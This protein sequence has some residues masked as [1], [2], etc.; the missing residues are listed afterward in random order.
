M[1]CRLI[2]AIVVSRGNVRRDV[3]EGSRVA[4][5]GP[6]FKSWLCPHVDTAVQ[7]LIRAVRATGVMT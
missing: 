6:T 4:L 1:Y 2:G 5:H 3:V 7:E